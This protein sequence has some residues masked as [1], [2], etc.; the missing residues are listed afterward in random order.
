M[1][2]SASL[3]G[4]TELVTQMHFARSTSTLRQQQT[5]HTF[6]TSRC[7]LPAL[8]LSSL[9]VHGRGSRRQDRA[10]KSSPGAQ[11]PGCRP[12]AQRQGLDGSDYA[13]DDA[14]DGVPDIWMPVPPTPALGRKRKVAVLVAAAMLEITMTGVFYSRQTG[15]D[16]QQTW[17]TWA[18]SGHMHVQ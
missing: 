17:C 14:D 13:Q 7:T 11:Q 4:I 1:N 15:I 18:G 8:G 9:Q 16:G 5:R 12:A 3:N 6:G 2:S 10:L